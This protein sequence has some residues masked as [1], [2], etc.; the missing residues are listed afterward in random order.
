M[1]ASLISLRG[2]TSTRV[3]YNTPLVKGWREL[4]LELIRTQMA[5][6]PMLRVEVGAR[7]VRNPVG[8]GGGAARVFEDRE[9]QRLELKMREPF[10]KVI[11]MAPVAIVELQEDKKKSSIE[12][13]NQPLRGGMKTSTARLATTSR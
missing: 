9:G 7:A 8:S 11:G 6:K 2:R 5:Q 3:M 13:I 4:E 12:N 10:A 1:S